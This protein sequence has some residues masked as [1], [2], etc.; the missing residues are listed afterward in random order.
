MVYPV[1]TMHYP[2]A[3][4]GFH[5]RYFTPHTPVS[6]ALVSPPERSAAAPASIVAGELIKA[7]NKAPTGRKGVAAR[8]RQ[9][10]LAVSNY[11]FV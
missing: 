3:L 10:Y 6:T 9:K 11:A 8:A 1:M 5:L 4:P 2:P 7:G